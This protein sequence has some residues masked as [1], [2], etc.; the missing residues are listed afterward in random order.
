[1]PEE[2]EI[3]TKELQET[4]EELREEREEREAQARKAAWTG[5]IALST[6]L[7]AVFAAIGALQSGSLVNEAMIHQL[8]AS[9][10]W[11][12]YQADRQKE[13]QFSLQANGL[14]DRGTSAP[15]QPAA[16][17]EGAASAGSGS[18]GSGGWHAVAPAERLRQYIEQVEKERAKEED[19]KKEAGKLEGEAREELH[20][21]HRFA[22]S[23]ALI[24]VAIA[25]GAVAALTRI[26]PVWVLS[27]VV[28]LGGIVLFAAG[29]L[30]I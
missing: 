30:S 5:Y 22:W 8:Q 14:L 25:L 16:P 9:D 24:Q 4:I 28:G 17:S 21:H 12:Q 13:Y 19:L 20:Q 26:R 27:L 2:V 1:M 15:S 29:L 10:T 18:E 7:L 23:V 3:E 11:N 6:A